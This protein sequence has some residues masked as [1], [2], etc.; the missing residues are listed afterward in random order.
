[1]LQK[2]LA[3]S[4]LATLQHFQLLQAKLMES[5]VLKALNWKYRDFMW[6]AFLKL[7]SLVSMKLEHM[8]CCFLC[9]HPMICRKQCKINFIVIFLSDCGFSKYY[10]IP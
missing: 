5:L 6:N 2:G 4:V 9:S 8:C 3:V 7:F 10:H 1:M